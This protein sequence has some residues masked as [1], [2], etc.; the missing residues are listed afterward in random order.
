MATKLWGPMLTGVAQ[1]FQDYQ[2]GQEDLAYT[3][4]ARMNQLASQQLANQ[5]QTLQNAQQQQTL[6]NAD[7]THKYW[8]SALQDNGTQ[9]GQATTQQATD[10][11]STRLNSSHVSLS[12]MPSSA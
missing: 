8:V 9:E 2:Q 11:K 10:R 4:Q 1:G 3:R 12:R 7:L 5:A 6:Q